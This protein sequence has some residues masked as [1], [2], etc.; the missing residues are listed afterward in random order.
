MSW[1]KAY[2]YSIINGEYAIIINAICKEEILWPDPVIV[3]KFE[4]AE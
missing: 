4:Y 1:H 3:N 2:L